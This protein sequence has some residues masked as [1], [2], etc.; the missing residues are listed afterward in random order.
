MTAGEQEIATGRSGRGVAL[1]E[2]RR[3]YTIELGLDPMGPPSVAQFE[4]P[5]G[6]T[7]RVRVE[8]D[9]I[10]KSGAITGRLFVKAAP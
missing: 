8:A 9:A 7:V 10:A 2:W 6:E 3:E 1:E 4:L 5:S